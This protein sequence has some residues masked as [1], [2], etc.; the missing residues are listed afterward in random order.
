MAAQRCKHWRGSEV[1]WPMEGSGGEGRTCWSYLHH[2]PPLGIRSVPRSFSGNC[3][4]EI[5]CIKR[6][7]REK[8]KVLG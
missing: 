3:Y 7:E 5:H 6:R 2:L 8:G 4:K 1:Q